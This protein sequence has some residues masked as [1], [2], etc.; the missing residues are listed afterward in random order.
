MSLF[1]LITKIIVGSFVAYIGY[2]VGRKALDA[3]NLEK[4]LTAP[5]WKYSITQL[6]ELIMLVSLVTVIV[7]A[8]KLVGYLG[9]W[10][11]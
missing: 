7:L 4:H 9:Q 2:G 6:G 1:L 5:H 3:I 8:V 10:L 11:N